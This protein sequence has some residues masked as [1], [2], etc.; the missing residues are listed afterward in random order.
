MFAV[1]IPRG[2]LANVFRP[3]GFRQLDLMSK[4]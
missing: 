2:Q 4:L 1:Q 3:I